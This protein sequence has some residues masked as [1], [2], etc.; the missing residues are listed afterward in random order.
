MEVCYCHLRLHNL[1]AFWRPQMELTSSCAPLSLSLWLCLCLPLSLFSNLKRIHLFQ[2]FSYVRVLF[3][4]DCFNQWGVIHSLKKITGPSF[5]IENSSILEI[6]VEVQANYV[7]MMI[8]IFVFFFFAAKILPSYTYWNGQILKQNIMS[9]VKFLLTSKIRL[10]CL[11]PLNFIV[12][13]YSYKY[14]NALWFSIY[15]YRLPSNFYNEYYD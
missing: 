12:P 3:C 4:M 14:N 5:S 13:I 9:I 10:L 6:E 7:A 2:R 15:L 8:P 1:L 11:K